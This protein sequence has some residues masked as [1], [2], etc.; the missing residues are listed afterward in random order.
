MKEMGANGYRTSHYPQAAELMDAR[1]AVRKD[2]EKFAVDRVKAA[3]GNKYNPQLMIDS[4]RDIANLTGEKLETSSVREALRQKQHTQ[5]QRK[6]WS[7]SEV[8]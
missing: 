3:Y 1:L 8:R 4:N 5:A 7:Q 6:A 2:R